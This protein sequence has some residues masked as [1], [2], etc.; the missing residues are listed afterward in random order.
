MRLIR[1][2]FLS[3]TALAS[4]LALVAPAQS[5]IDNLSDYTLGGLMKPRGPEKT[6]PGEYKKAGPYKI[7]F[8][9]A[10]VGNSWIVQSFEEAEVEVAHHKDIVSYVQTNAEWQPTKQVSDL[11][12]VLTK[13][14][15]A[16]ILSTVTPTNANAELEKFAARKI[17]VVVVGTGTTGDYAVE[18]RGGAE[19]FGRVGG[20]FLVKQ[21]HGKGTVWAFRGIAGVQEEVER[22]NGFASALKGTGITIGAEEY[23]DWN[24]AKSK[25]LCQNLVLSGK[26]VDG[27]WFSGAEMTRACVDVFKQANKPLVPMTGEGNNGFFRIWKETGMNSV[28][29]VFPPSLT[30][31]AV[32]VTLALLRGESVPKHMW[33]EPPAL[34]NTTYQKYYRPDLNDNYWVPSS[35]PEPEIKTLYAK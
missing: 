35:L 1:Q 12:D 34:N 3:A 13:N 30:T 14:V 22:Y 9:A 6:T 15:D 29:A 8:V 18:V 4:T 23:G 31:S 10:G 32:R 17:P 19:H 33:S 27:I 11:E 5:Q 16:I 2:A 25:Q 24:Y 26:P 20:D 28:A 21:L 7:A